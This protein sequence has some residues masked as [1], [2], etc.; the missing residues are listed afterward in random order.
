MA[1]VVKVN[2]GDMT[3]IINKLKNDVQALQTCVSEMSSVSRNLGNTWTGPSHDAYEEAMR[4]D[5]IEIGKFI[6]EVREYIRAIDEN[7][8]AYEEDKNNFVAMFNE[9][10]YSR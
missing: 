10:N 9:R 2:T 5:L 7:G 6:N 3:N 4:N 1:G 8:M